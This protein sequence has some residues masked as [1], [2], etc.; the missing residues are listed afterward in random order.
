MSVTVT[1]DPDGWWWVVSEGGIALDAFE[2][3]TDAW[4]YATYYLNQTSNASVDY[5]RGF[6]Q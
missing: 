3:R 6:N 2:S 1:R 4:I 5:N